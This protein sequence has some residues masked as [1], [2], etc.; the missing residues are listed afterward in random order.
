M[1]QEKICKIQ[2][3]KDS[4]VFDKLQI[5]SQNIMDKLAVLCDK[6]CIQLCAEPYGT[7]LS[8]S[9]FEAAPERPTKLVQESESSRGE[10][11]YGIHDHCVFRQD[12]SEVNP[13]FMY[14]IATFGL[15]FMFHI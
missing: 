2:A 6:H 3:L 12:S 10:Q 8:A 9:K 14:F 5:I 7:E 4:A 13:C 15:L 11:L 1:A